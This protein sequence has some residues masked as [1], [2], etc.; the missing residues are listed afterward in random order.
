MTT[1]SPDATH[2]SAGR[3][4]YRVLTPASQSVRRLSLRDFRA[5]VPRI[6]SRSALASKESKHAAPS[7]PCLVRGTRRHRRLRRGA[8]AGRPVGRRRA[9]LCQ[10]QHDGRQH[11][12]RV[13]P[14]RGRVPDTPGR[15][16][17]SRSVGPAPATASPR[18]A[19]SRP[20]PTAGTWSRWTPVAVSSPWSR[21]HR[22]GTPTLVG[23]PVSSGGVRPVSLTISRQGLAYVANVGDGGSNYTGFRLGDDGSLAAVPKSTVPGPEGSGVGDVFFNA[24]ADRLVGTRDNTSLIDSFTVRPT[25]RRSPRPGPPSLRRTSGRSVQ[26]S[27]PP[28]PLS[29]MSAT[30]TPAPG[31]ALSRRST[32]TAGAS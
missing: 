24:T 9:C 32:S 30:P 16:R 29:C 12:R 11:G 15:G 5:W 10:R 6:V 22:D 18:R 13:R 25:S 31:T 1:D 28:T 19:P 14:P 2:Y 17:P 21:L 8:G 23:H 27:G 7:S 3:M 26:S 4:H 20:H